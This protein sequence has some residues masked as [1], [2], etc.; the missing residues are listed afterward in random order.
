MNYKGFRM[1]ST[2]S[3]GLVA[4]QR[5][6]LRLGREGDGALLTHLQQIDAIRLALAKAG[7]PL[8]VGSGKHSKPKISFGP[9]VS[10]GYESESEYFDVE[11]V[12]RLDIKKAA[13]ELSPHLPKGYFFIGLRS[14]PR[15]FPSLEE[16]VNLA[17]FEACSS[18][19]IGT[20]NKWD[21]FFGK[22][23]FIVVK[24]KG[25]G[26]VL[27]DA[28]PLVRD[29]CLVD[30]KIQLSLRFG[31]GKTLKPERIIQ[32]VCGWPETAVEMGSPTCALTVRRKQFFLEKETGELI[33]P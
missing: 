14:I 20:K 11:L 24:K 4:L 3:D 33:E 10:V 8:L 2:P 29:Y 22:T 19:L 7:W 27:I 13:A 5:V 21:E 25:S 17:Q 1:T 31:P 16:M 28:R 32:A 26:D 9:A 12:S 18:L 6:R 15:F 23:S 30:S